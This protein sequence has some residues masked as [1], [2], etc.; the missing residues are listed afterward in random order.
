MFHAAID[1]VWVTSAAIRRMQLGRVD[2]LP[3]QRVAAASDSWA[4]WLHLA[5]VQL[6]IIGR[7]SR[8]DA[9]KLERHRTLA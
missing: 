3:H 2:R 7:L 1:P 8:I 5:V 9:V 6:H 4:C